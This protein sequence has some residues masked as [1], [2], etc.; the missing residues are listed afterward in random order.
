MTTS[1]STPTPNAAPEIRGTW[2]PGTAGILMIIGGAVVLL[3]GVVI[4]SLSSITVI[5]TNSWLFGFFGVPHIICG[6]LSIIGGAF[7]IKRRYWGLALAGSITALWVPMSLLGILSII[8]VVLS[9]NE[10]K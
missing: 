10:F 6:V 1:T 8:F 3:I 4:A 7:A 5:F 2:M 9:K